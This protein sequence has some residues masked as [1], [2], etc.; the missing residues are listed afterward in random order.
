M[1]LG[2]RH[3]PYTQRRR[4]ADHRGT[5]QDASADDS[6]NAGPDGAIRAAPAGR[7]HPGAVLHAFALFAVRRY[8]AAGRGRGRSVAAHPR[9]LGRDGQPGR[10]DRFKLRDRGRPH[11]RASGPGAVPLYRRRRRAFDRGAAG[12]FRNHCLSAPGR[13]KAGDVD[14]AVHGQLHPGRGGIDAGPRKLRQLDLPRRLSPAFPGPPAA[15]G[16]P[17]RP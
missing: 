11:R 8:A 13:P 4:R 2:E 14:R 7:V 3:R 16:P 1:K 5:D 12:R 9:G 6:R 10:A 17:L 15:L